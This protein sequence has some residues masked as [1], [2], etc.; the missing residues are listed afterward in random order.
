[1]SGNTGCPQK[2]GQCAEEM[3]QLEAQ[4]SH[5]ESAVKALSDR[6]MS[7]CTPLSP[8]VAQKPAD[9]AQLVPLASAMRSLSERVR[10]SRSAL[11]DLMGSVEL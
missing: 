3:G 6:L 1:M 11:Q 7:V 10:D 5:L 9:G 4:V 8:E 2:N